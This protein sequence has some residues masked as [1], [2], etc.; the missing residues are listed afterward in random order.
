M[1][2][3]TYTYTVQQTPQQVFAAINNV[4]N[5]WAGDI[6]GSTSE[7]G[8]EFTYSAGNVHTSTHRITESVPGKRVVWSIPSAQLTFLK[9]PAEWVGTEV[10]FDIVATAD[11]TEL[12]FTHKGLVPEIECFA[13]C[14]DGWGF[15]INESLR[16]YMT[17]GEGPLTPPW[18]S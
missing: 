2:D 1:N 17:T 13:A 9:D 14:S 10:I 16:H 12:T 5:W 7:L 18:A 6:E 15:F 4:R 11:G 8:S 3:L